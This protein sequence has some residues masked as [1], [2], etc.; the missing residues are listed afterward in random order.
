MVVA[1]RPAGS[2]IL[3]DGRSLLG[4]GEQ[5]LLTD[6]LHPD[7]H[8]ATLVTQRFV[9][10]TDDK[11]GTLYPFFHTEYATAARSIESNQRSS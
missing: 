8:G 3:V 10:A 1:A 6:G 2:V 5:H 4:A 7:L 11:V 9:A